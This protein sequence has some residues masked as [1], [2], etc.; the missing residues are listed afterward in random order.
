M[1]ERNIQ[2]TALARLFSATVL[3][4]LAK[5]GESPTFARLLRESGLQFDE[6]SDS[7]IGELFDLAFSLL[8][9]RPN[10][11]E[12][13]YKAALTQKILLGTHSLSTASMLTE[14]RAGK[15]KADVV[16]LNGTGTVYEIKSERDSLTRLMSQIEAYSQVFATVNV[17]A[18]ANHIQ[19]IAESAPSHV[20][21][22]MLSD[23][24]QVSTIREAANQPWR[25]NPC[26]IFDSIN[27]LEA[28][29]ILQE[30][31]IEVPS[32]PNTRRYMMLRSLFASLDPE[33]AHRGMV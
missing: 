14:F 10:R 9:L 16:I 12:Y 17:I 5:R 7:W 4:E 29:S 21:I 15:C 13:I 2:A 23:R 3:G 8:K 19:G 32:V 26:A 11:H 20:G 27:Q 28:Q 6:S 24:Y 25:T 30:Y 18:G 22:L 33:C 31:G 1:K